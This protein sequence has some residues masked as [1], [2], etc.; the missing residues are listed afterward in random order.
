[1][2]ILAFRGTGLLC[3]LIRWFTWGP[4]AHISG[5]LPD[6]TVIESSGSVA[7]FIRWIFR[8]PQKLGVRHKTLAEAIKEHGTRVDAFDVPG[9][10]ELGHEIAESFA[11]S[12]TGKGYAYRGILGFLAREHAKEKAWF[13][14]D[15]IFAAWSQANFSLLRAV[16]YYKV[17]PTLLSYSSRIVPCQ[18]PEGCTRAA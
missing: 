10:A 7:D 2:K 4:Y 5:W 8:R 14:S 15:L 11:L 13:C 16:P 3:T 9:A 6:D 18:R 1:M 12:Q 17:S